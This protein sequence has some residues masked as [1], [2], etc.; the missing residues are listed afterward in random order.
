[1]TGTLVEQVDKLVQ[2]GKRAPLLS[3]TSNTAAI[4]ELVARTEAL[5]S[6][7]REVAFEVQKLAA[8]KL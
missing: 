3:T 8:R 1:M 2:A 4:Q 5:E 6:A 7:L